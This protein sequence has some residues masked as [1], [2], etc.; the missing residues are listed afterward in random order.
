M[1]ITPEGPITLTCPAAP[2][3]FRLQS[4][5]GSEHLGTLYQYQLKLACESH[6][7]DLVS[8]LG[9][10]LTVHMALGND[11]FRH[12]GGIISGI[13]RGEREVDHTAYYVTLSPEHELLS[14]S[15][16]CRIF[17][18]VTVVDVVKQIAAF[19]HLRPCREALFDQYRTWD[20]LTQYRESDMDFIRRIL[21]LEGI[22]FY[23]D[24]LEDGPQMVLADSVSSHQA[25]KGWDTV[26]VLKGAAGR[27]SIPDR[28]RWWQESS[29]LATNGV[30][31]RDCDFRARCSSKVFDGQKETPDAQ[32]QGALNR[33]EY[34]GIFTLNENRVDADSRATLTEGE[35]L[36]RVRLEEKQSRLLRYQGEG[37][38]RNLQVGSLFSVS[39]VPALAKR[40][41]LIIATDV[42]FRNPDFENGHGPLGEASYAS[43][44]AIDS[45][46][47]FRMPRLEKPI[48]PGPQTARVVGPTEEEIWTDKY[49]RIR[50]QF[51]WDRDKKPKDEDRSCWVRVAHPWAG[52]RWGAIHIPR[53]GSEVVVEFLE[54]DPDR[55]LVTG[56]V[57]NADNMPPYT[58]PEN[59][60]QSGIKTRSSKGGTQANFNELRFEDKKGHE[61]LHLQAE[62]NMSTLVKRDQSL[63]VRGDRSATVNGNDTIT[64]DGTRESIITNDETQFFKANRKM[65]IQGAST[66]AIFGAHDG[67]YYGG[68]TQAIENG[69][70]LVVIGSDKRTSVDGEYKV[71]ASA[72]Y[73]VTSGDSAT[74]SMDLQ[75]GIIT[76]TAANE[77]NLVCGTA[78]LSLKSDGTVTIQ[79]KKTLSATGADSKLELASAGATLSGQNATIS[80]KTMTDISGGMVK[81]N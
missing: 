49:G 64:V 23:F 47:P 48:I 8:L 2:D 33:Y 36:A 80:G 73:R 5:S 40:Q 58:L 34:P 32:K 68:R 28:L 43:V 76:I 61:E 11:E 15:H 35:R 31:L 13:R 78:S 38:A 22:Y 46:R 17:Q 52:N 37:T 41:F 39:H 74:S 71:E 51:H 81:I 14:F 44:T 42:A 57:Y 19:H 45:D 59:K 7:V 26:P 9:K 30:S 72:H 53:M 70:T 16:D 75:D 65:A 25:R 55:P 12:F 62:R 4:I 66:E 77:I 67:T 60:T 10:A 6:D 24:H 21:A 69:D 56:S 54:G 20:Y 79:G 63:T 27:G 50:V 1:D 18:N 3:V 29:E